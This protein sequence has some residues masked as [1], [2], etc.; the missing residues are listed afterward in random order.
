ML[1]QSYC[2]IFFLFI[3]TQIYIFAKADIKRSNEMGHFGCS[4][5]WE[6]K[7]KIQLL[8][9]LLADDPGSIKQLK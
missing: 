5:K 3:T 1:P 7:N 6:E 2:L 8:V 4:I 9:L